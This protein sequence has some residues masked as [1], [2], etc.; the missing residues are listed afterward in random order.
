[1]Q[2]QVAV[3]VRHRR[4][5]VEEEPHPGV[6]AELPVAAPAI[7]GRALDVLENQIGLAA[8]RDAGIEQ[9]GDVRMREAGEEAAFAPEAFGADAARQAQV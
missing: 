5:H 2:D 8:V 7:D 4:E 3:R 1:M 6:D 9:P